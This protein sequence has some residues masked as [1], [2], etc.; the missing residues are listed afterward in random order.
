MATALNM[1]GSIEN[2]DDIL[3]YNIDSDDYDL[4]PDFCCWLAKTDILKV[5]GKFDENFQRAYFEDNDFHYRIKLLGF[6]AIKVVNAPMYHYGSQTQNADPN[7]P[8]VPPPMF[9]ENREYYI[10]KWGGIPG[11]ETYT[12]PYNNLQ[13][14][15]RKWLENV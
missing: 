10:K 12:H 1:R 9:I 3:N 4:N 8:V 14:S 13:L 2:P 5:I 6:E 15:P 7:N 11:F